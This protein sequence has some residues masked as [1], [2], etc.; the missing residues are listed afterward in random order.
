MC[1][2]WCPAH[3]VDGELTKK[4]AKVYEFFVD[5]KGAFPSVDMGRLRKAMEK[6]GVERILI[7]RV[8]EN[9]GNS[10]PLKYDADMTEMSPADMEMHLHFYKK[11]FES[12]ENAQSKKDGLAV[13]QVGLIN[14]GY[15]DPDYSF[16]KLEGE[17]SKVESINSTSTIGSFPLAKYV[18]QDWIKEYLFYKGS[19]DYPPCDE[20]VTWFIYEPNIQISPEL[21]SGFGKIKLEGEDSTNI[22]PPQAVNDRK[23]KMLVASAIFFT[24]PTSP[25]L[26][27]NSVAYFILRT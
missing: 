16:D 21:L 26:I 12:F 27:L 14:G 1:P 5:L 23:I 2:E 25:L 19:L 13:F 24:S 18:D 11:D 22:R 4:G 17:L 9:D 10:E 3:V 6:R 20:S 8:R 15:E 7:E